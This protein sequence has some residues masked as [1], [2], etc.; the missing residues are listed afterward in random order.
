MLDEVEPGA[1]DCS[2]GALENGAVVVDALVLLPVVEEPS[3]VTVRVA[4][5]DE[6]GTSVRAAYTVVGVGTALTHESHVR[7][8][9]RVFV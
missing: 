8:L 7:G 5:L 9:W 3:A 1:A 2:A 6:K 4:W